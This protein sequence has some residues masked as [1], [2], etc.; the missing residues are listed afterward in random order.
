[1]ALHRN[2]Q[3]IVFHCFIQYRINY[4]QIT[5][6]K[7]IL[8]RELI[9]ADTLSRSTKAVLPVAYHALVLKGVLCLL[10]LMQ[11]LFYICYL[12]PFLDQCT[13]HLYES[14]QLLYRSFLV[15]RNPSRYKPIAMRNIY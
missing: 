12:I 7:P 8:V 4:Q 15:E 14:A 3:L 1:M 2:S 5:T 9:S 11:L 6:C 13:F 10:S